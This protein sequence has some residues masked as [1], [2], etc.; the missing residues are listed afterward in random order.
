[1]K[2]GD[3]TL[4]DN[5]L[6][7]WGSSGGTENAHNNTNLPTMLVGGHKLGIKHQGHLEKKDVR[8]GN[9]WQTMF[10]VMG[11]EVPKDFQGG[12]ADGVLKEL[13]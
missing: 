6:L 2:E 10:G 7:V 13:V 8:L 5:T 9:L 3:G 11:V 4:L 12:E 1:V